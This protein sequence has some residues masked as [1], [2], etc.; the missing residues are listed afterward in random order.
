MRYVKETGLVFV[1]TAESVSIN[2]IKR[3]KGQQKT[4]TYL[5]HTVF[6]GY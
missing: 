1:F 3:Q 5:V 6:H 4:N 2:K